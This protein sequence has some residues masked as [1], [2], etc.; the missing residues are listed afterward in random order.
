MNQSAMKEKIARLRERLLFFFFPPKCAVCG[1]TGYK[2]LCPQCRQ[3]LEEAFDPKKF[4]ASGGNS[5]ADGM[6]TLFV[7]DEYAV[8]KLLCDWK[9]EEF[10][11]LPVIFTP[12]MKRF[13]GKKL[14]PERIH[15]IAFLP[16]RRWSRWKI[17]FDQAQRITCIFSRLSHLPQQ[18]LLIRQGY[19]KPQ[20]KA[21]YKNRE[22]NI[23]GAFRAEKPLIGET[24]LL[25]DDIVT[26]GATAREGARILKQAGAMKVYILSLAH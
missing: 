5:F 22:K 3:K 25:V 24:V 26:T 19:A 15:C 7:Y 23:R 21:K 8:K 9:Q 13:L 17:G 10:R 4:R 2:P 18:C 1:A 20:H 6:Y 14:L 11:D 16:R 12:F